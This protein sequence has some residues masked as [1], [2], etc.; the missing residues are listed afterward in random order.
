MKQGSS[1]L[2]LRVIQITHRPAFELTPKKVSQWVKNLPIANLGET[3]KSTYRLLVDCNQA[4][5]DPDKR[6]DILNVI[7]PVI[8]QLTAALEKQFINNHITLSEKQRK[9]AALLQAI[10]TEIAIGYHTVIET[11]VT[12]EVKRSNKKLLSRAI[13]MA[14]EYHGLV[15]LRC[16]QL[17]TS[18]PNRLWR[19]L[20]CLFQIAR[21]FELENQPVVIE[22]TRKTVTSYGGFIR[23]LL[24]SIANPYQLRQQEINILWEI[25]PELGEH[26]SLMTHAYNKQHY[27][28]ALDSSS[29]P[30]HKSLH[31]PQANNTNNL[32]LTAFTAVEHL[33]QMLTSITGT[34]QQNIRKSMLL[35]H[36]IQCWSHGIHRSFART[37]CSEILD[38]SIGLGSTHYLLM[39]TGQKNN[40]D[41]SGT[42]DTLEAMEGSLKDATLLDIAKK[43]ESNTDKNINYLSSS[44]APDEDAWAKLYRPGQVMKQPISELDKKNRSK[45]TIVKNSYKLLQVELLN[46]SPGGYC[47]QIAS[48]DLPKHAQTGEI[49][50]FL[51]ED[52]QS[53]ENWSIGVVRWVRRLNKGTAVQMG[54]Q[55]LAPAAIPINIQLRNSQVDKNEYQRALL[56][57]ALPGVGQ[58]STILTNPLSF[59]MQ[60]KV[61]ILDHG[62]EYDSRL[63]KE[64]AFSSSFRQFQFEKVDNGSKKNKSPKNDPPFD[65]QELDGIWDLI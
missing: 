27:I 37:S 13:A 44:S 51:E 60:S 10:Q 50:G 49:M 58:P 47:I 25:L 26:A 3:S 40:E 57:P 14:I 28:V 6:L 48:D 9:I 31:Q 42:K 54:V 2:T 22:Q 16:F 61:R 19:E 52:P 62:Q 5:L 29:P 15:I 64:V 30:I 39:Q 20:Y 33:K 55:L 18:I 41:L 38:I 8:N 24:L 56:L 35:R 17:Y 65:S 59:T 21:Q 46:M 36:L 1:G 32:K 23:V 43:A 11:I 45:D 12:S 34:A 7:E 4:L 53:R 63:T